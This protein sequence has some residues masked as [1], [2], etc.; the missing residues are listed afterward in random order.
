LRSS[1]AILAEVGYHYV[2]AAR[3]DRLPG[4][5]HPAGCEGCQ[6]EEEQ[7]TDHALERHQGVTFESDPF[8]GGTPNDLGAGAHAGA[9]WVV[10]VLT[11]SFGR[12]ALSAGP[13]THVLD[14]I[15]GLPE[16]LLGKR[17]S[18]AARAG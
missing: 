5:D 18:P 3:Q 10:G 6:H 4:C 16:L 7:C 17:I 12:E 15:A 8:Q 2:A 11:G 9:G 1:V 13:A 14:S